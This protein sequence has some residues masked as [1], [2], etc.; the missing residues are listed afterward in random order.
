MLGVIAALP[1]LTHSLPV[2]PPVPFTPTYPLPS[3]HHAF[4]SYSQLHVS[5]LCIHSKLELQQAFP[6]SPVFL[7][8]VSALPAVPAAASRRARVTSQEQQGIAAVDRSKGETDVEDASRDGRID[9]DPG[10]A[11]SW[12]RPPSHVLSTTVHTC[13][14]SFRSCT[15]IVPHECRKRP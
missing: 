2:F 4:Q 11:R 13:V 8:S 6:A 12:A 1:S 9:T 15:H 10:A 5:T 14:V 3:I 7:T